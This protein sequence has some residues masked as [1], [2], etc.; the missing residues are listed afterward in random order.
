M[1]VP[2]SDVTVC[3]ARPTHR[4]PAC[5]AARVV[6]E[7]HGGA[8][9]SSYQGLCTLPGVGDYTAGAVASIAF[10]ERV[11]A[12]DGNVRRVFAR[13]FDRAEP[14]AAWLRATA[15]QMVCA[16]RPGDWNQALMELGATVCTPRSPKCGECPLTKRAP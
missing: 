6:R 10:G 8:I 15:A 14:M 9:P 5:G 16:E 3:A 13:L 11:P 1:I 7:T 4:R 12:V 2:D